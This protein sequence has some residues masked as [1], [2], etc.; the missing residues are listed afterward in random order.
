M[1]MAMFLDNFTRLE[2]KFLKFLEVSN[3][4]N[5]K[6]KA[7]EKIFLNGDESSNAKSYINFCIVC[8]LYAVFSWLVHMLHPIIHICEF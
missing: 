6:M 1:P 5:L 2:C 4:L 3:F 7:W 8:T